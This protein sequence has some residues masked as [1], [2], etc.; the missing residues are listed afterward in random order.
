MSGTSETV[1]C[2]GSLA[3]N[4]TNSMGPKWRMSHHL[5]LRADGFPILAYVATRHGYFLGTL[6]ALAGTGERNI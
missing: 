5:N 2:S 4:N 1:T 6:K 3:G